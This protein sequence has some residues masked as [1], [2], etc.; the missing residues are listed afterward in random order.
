M[1]VI[2]EMEWVYCSARTEFLTIF[3][4]DVLLSN[5]KSIVEQAYDVLK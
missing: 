4:V 2:T 5:V 3:L 1:A